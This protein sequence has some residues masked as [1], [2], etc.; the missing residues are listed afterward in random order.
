MSSSDPCCSRQASSIDKS[1]TVQ[2]CYVMAPI[3]FTTEFTKDL[4]DNDH[5]MVIFL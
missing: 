1:L 5:K 3:F 2:Y 4:Q